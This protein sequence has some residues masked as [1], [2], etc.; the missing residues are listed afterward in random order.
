MSNRI[1]IRRYPAFFKN[2]LKNILSPS[3]LKIDALDCDQAILFE[4]TKARL[5]W[6]IQG[7]TAV[8]VFINH[9]KHG[10]YLPADTPNIPITLGMTITV[11]ASAL[12]RSRKARFCPEVLPLQYH[13]ANSLHLKANFLK[14]PATITELDLP[15]IAYN[16][17]TPAPL[18]VLKSIKLNSLMTATAETQ[19]MERMSLYEQQI[20][21][22][23]LNSYY[24]NLLL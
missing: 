17:Q 8:S 21:H 22:Q 20:D 1:P 2:S 4:N 5:V 23:T 7:A 14:A 13:A 24:G 19:L 18:I 15:M 16:I 3:K 10:V 9:K 11:K 12:F 6:S